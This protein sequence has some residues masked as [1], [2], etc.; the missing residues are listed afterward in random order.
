LRIVDIAQTGRDPR[1]WRLRCSGPAPMAPAISE[2]C[3]ILILIILMIL[4]E[5]VAYYNQ[6]VAG[7]PP[8]MA[9]S[10]NR[11]RARNRNRNRQFDHDHD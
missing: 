7:A 2:E 4:I 9:S 10:P 1:S 3:D 6:G 11:A 5:T 8:S